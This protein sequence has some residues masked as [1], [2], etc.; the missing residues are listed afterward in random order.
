MASVLQG[1][2]QIIKDGDADEVMKRIAALQ[3]RLEGKGKLADK[4]EPDLIPPPPLK[5]VGR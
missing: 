3:E 5:L 1:A 4:P 2:G